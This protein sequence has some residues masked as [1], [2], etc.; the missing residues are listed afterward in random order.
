MMV[1]AEKVWVW[2]KLYMMKASSL[3]NCLCMEDAYQKVNFKGASQFVT[4]MDYRLTREENEHA[5]TRKAQ[6]AKTPGS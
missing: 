5:S 4:F 2:D 3:A 1:K 6:T